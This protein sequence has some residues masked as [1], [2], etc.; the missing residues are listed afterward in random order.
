MIGPYERMVD[1]GEAV[2]TA[3][4]EDPRSTAV[5][6]KGAVE[7]LCSLR[8]RFVWEGPSPFAGSLSVSVIAS[9]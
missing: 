3:I 2:L 9:E 4:S 1:V 8:G 6:T 7:S 5:F